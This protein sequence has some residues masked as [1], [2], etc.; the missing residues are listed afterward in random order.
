MRFFNLGHPFFSAGAYTESDKA[1]RSER[2]W[3]Q[4]T[5]PSAIMLFLL[6]LRLT[7]GES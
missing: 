6:G 4:Q 1:L 2:I 3:L 5:M 7:T